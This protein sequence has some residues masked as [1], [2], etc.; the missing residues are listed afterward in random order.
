MILRFIWNSSCSDTVVELRNAN[1]IPCS[2]SARLCFDP[3]QR[4]QVVPPIKHI[5]LSVGESGVGEC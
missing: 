2:K 1:L 4:I 5:V 3:V